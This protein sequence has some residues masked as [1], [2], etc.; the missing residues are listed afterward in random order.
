MPKSSSAA[1]SRFRPQ[2]KN[3]RLR[4]LIDELKSETAQHRRDLD[5][6]FQRIAA[7]QAQVDDLL[8]KH[9]RRS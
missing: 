5:V 6:Q 2:R 8:A 3:K 9:Q 1:V 4:T 7:L